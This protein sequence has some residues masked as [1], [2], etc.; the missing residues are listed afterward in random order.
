[1]FIYTTFSVITSI[2]TASQSTD[3]AI[4][5]VIQTQAG[6]NLMI[7]SGDYLEFN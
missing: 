7:E 1:M 4:D 3:Q 6:I 5:G 2:I